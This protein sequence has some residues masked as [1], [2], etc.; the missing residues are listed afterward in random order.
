MVP[1]RRGTALWCGVHTP[2]RGGGGGL[3]ARTATEGG[4]VDR[5]STGGGIPR[6]FSAVGPVL[7]RGGGGEAR[8][9][10]GDHRGGVNLTGGG[11][12]RPVCGAVAGVHGGEVAG[13]AVVFNRGVEECL[14]TV[15]VW[16]SSSTRLIQPKFTWEGRT[17][18]TGAT[19][20]C[21]GASSIGSGRSGGDGRSWCGGNGARAA[22]FIGARERERDG[23]GSERRRARHDGGN[24]A[25]GD[26]DGSGRRGVRGRLGYSGRV[27]A[28]AGASLNGEATGR[29]TVGGERAG[30]AW[31]GRRC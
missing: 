1:D 18:L 7:R 10:A 29:E 3:T 26:W 16:R 5:S 14:V 4:G 30:E 8:A 23:G 25:N 6:R 22:P 20:K 12:G 9:G 11:L 24:G 19:G 28:E 15:S 27:I 21:G 2:A 17:R 13:E 31:A